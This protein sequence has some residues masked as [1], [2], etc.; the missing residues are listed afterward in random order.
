MKIC[1]DNKLIRSMI[2]NQDDGSLAYLFKDYQ[3]DSIREPLIDFGEN[4]GDEVSS[5]A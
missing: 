3:D 2:E 5:K 1:K 4:V